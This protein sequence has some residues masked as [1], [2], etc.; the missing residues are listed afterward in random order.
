M[1]VTARGVMDAS[2]LYEPP[3][4]NLHTGGPDALFAGKE[5]VVEGILETLRGF[6]SALT[7]RAG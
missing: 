2:A 3:F 4:N 5:N 1:L 7:P 6:N